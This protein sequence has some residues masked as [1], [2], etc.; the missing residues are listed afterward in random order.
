MQC[1]FCKVILT[2]RELSQSH[3]CSAVYPMQS[4]AIKPAMVTNAHIIPSDFSAITT[5]FFCN[6]FLRKP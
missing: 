5:C 3:S 4:F 1:E 6:N 2:R